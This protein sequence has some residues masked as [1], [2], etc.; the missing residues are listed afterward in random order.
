MKII[1][2]LIFSCLFL[3]ANAQFD[4]TLQKAEALADVPLNCIEKEYPNKLGQV[5]N[6][7]SDLKTPEALHPVFY[8]CFD[9]HSSVH[10]H[11]LLSKFVNDYPGTD[12]S[13]NIS[14]RWN[15]RFTTIKV[16]K[17]VNYFM[18]ENNKNYER[19]YGWAWLL[20]LQ[21]EFNISTNKQATDWART[22]LPLTNTIVNKFK[23]FL[24]KLAYPI[25]VGEHTNTAFAL[26]FALEYARNVKDLEFEKLI[27]KSAK[28][29]YLND[30]LSPLTWE[31][32]GFDFLSPTLTE[33]NL[34]AEVLSEAEFSKWIKTFLPSILKSNFTLTPGIVNDRTDG[35][36]VHLDGL[37]FSRAWCLYRLSKHLPKQK[38]HLIS[39]ADQH[40]EASMEQVIGSDYM[41]SHWLASFLVYALDMRKE[42][43]Q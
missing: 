25:R 32:S 23:K 22:L 15:E 21:T 12:L 35:K 28:D 10:G 29:F 9:W 8:G 24:P 11:W 18:V 31:P 34:M 19:T 43:I 4:L 36:L 30:K 1:S 7:Q 3:T 2:Y 26:T 27:V 33:A 13:N 42:A 39:I 38:D 17:E 5:L 14:N 6:G 37:N 20:K 41:G 16:I 40:L